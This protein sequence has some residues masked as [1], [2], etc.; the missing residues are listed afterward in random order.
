MKL[1]RSDDG[2]A[3]VNDDDGDD[4]D[5]PLSLSCRSSRIN[6]AINESL[7]SRPTLSRQQVDGDDQDGRR[8]SIVLAV[9]V[10]AANIAA[11]KWVVMSDKKDTANTGFVKTNQDSSHTH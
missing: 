8:R 9:A 3:V 4:D 2:E 11:R 10:Y 5:G 7:M 6:P 1:G